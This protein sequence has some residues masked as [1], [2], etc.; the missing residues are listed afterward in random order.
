[1]MLFLSKKGHL[2]QV[3]VDKKKRVQLPLHSF[4]RHT[5]L[6][7]TNV[8]P[9]KTETK[10]YESQFY[11]L[12]W[13]MHLTDHLNSSGEIQTTVRYLAFFKMLSRLVSLVLYQRV[14]S[15]LT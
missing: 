3:E 10:S 14:L 12:K 13:C 5:S 4:Y 9:L 2:L 15:G 8:L 1:M 11:Y 7:I 6:I